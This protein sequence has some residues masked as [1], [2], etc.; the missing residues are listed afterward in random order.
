V[1]VLVVIK[2]LAVVAVP[3][4]A[5][6][7][8]ILS[9]VE[10]AAQEYLMPQYLQERLAVVV[11]VALTAQD[12][13]AAKDR[14][15]GPR[16]QLAALKVK[17]RYRT[18]AVVAVAQVTAPILQAAMADRALLSYSQS[19]TWLAANYKYILGVL[20]NGTFCKN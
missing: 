4:E 14:A 6:F 7:M 5:D 12:N 17:M 1:V 18:E 15:V 10:M 11:A 2:R 3:V 19:L 8:E 20:I 13:T 16:E 9:V